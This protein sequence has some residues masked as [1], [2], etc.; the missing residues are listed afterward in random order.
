MKSSVNIIPLMPQRQKPL[1]LFTGPP[2]LVVTPT[3]LTLMDPFHRGLIQGSSDIVRSPHYTK[4]RAPAIS[5]Q[6]Q[7]RNGHVSITVTPTWAQ[8]ARKM[9]VA[10]L[11]FHRTLGPK[12]ALQVHSY[13]LQKQQQ[14]QRHT[15]LQVHS[16]AREHQPRHLLH[17]ACTPPHT[18]IK[19]SS[20]EPRFERTEPVPEHKIILTKV[21][22]SEAKAHS[23]AKHQQEENK[24]KMLTSVVA[25]SERD[26]PKDVPVSRP[27]SSQPQTQS[28]E[29]NKMEEASKN[30]KRKVSVFS[31]WFTCSIYET[32]YIVKT[33]FRRISQSSWHSVSLYIMT[34]ACLNT[35]YNLSCM[36]HRFLCQINPK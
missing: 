25:Q 27:A 19:S 23:P 10:S 26:K 29:L 20:Q 21:E 4:T 12:D 6:S 18:Q 5:S 15:Q 2:K 7:T 3:K 34:D 9:G 13:T 22:Q 30:N 14:Q 1:I 28:T 36:H 35:G 11:L 17:K 31:L 8:P 24:P 32:E 33:F 16:Y